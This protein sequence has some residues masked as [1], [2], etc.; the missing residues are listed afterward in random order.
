MNRWTYFGF[1]LLVSACSPPSQ[2][3]LVTDANGQ[4]AI[5]INTAGLT[6]YNGTCLEIKRG[7]VRAIGHKRARIPNGIDVSD[8]TV[9]PSEY[10]RLLQSAMLAGGPGSGN[11]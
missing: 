9:T 3:S 6:C 7:S 10:R 11:R 5:Q 8:G 4:T 2:A 1:D